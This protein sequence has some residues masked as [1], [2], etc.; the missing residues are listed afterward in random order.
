VLPSFP[1][2]LIDGT[3]PSHLARLLKQQ[4]LPPFFWKAMLRGRE[5]MAKP[6]PVTV[7]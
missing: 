1:N 3:K 2:W 4:L 5:W 7:S 6:Q